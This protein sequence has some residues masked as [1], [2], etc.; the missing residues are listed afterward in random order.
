MFFSFSGSLWN[1]PF[2]P[3]SLPP[4]LLS[5]FA[6]VTRKTCAGFLPV[7]WDDYSGARRAPSEPRLKSWLTGGNSLWMLIS[8][9]QSLQSDVVMLA[10]LERNHVR[11]TDWGTDRQT[12]ATGWRTWGPE[13]TSQ[14]QMD[15]GADRY[16][17]LTADAGFTELAWKGILV[18]KESLWQ[19]FP[20]RRSNSLSCTP[21][22]LSSG[23]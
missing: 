17:V 20:P 3:P 21:L 15:A 19:L 8:P 13:R 6:V 7:C 4:L 23:G 1:L 12:S 22:L 10:Q 16:K 9:L 11:L 2:L 5:L 14:Q 18:N